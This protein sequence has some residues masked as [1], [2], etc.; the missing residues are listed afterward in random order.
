MNIIFYYYT[1]HSERNHQEFLKTKKKTNLKIR[2][3]SLI[4]HKPAKVV[5][6]LLM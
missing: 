3:M 2:T 6:C 4:V 1:L 5:K